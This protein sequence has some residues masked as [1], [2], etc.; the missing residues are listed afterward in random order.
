MCRRDAPGTGRQYEGPLT[1]WKGTAPGKAC[2]GRLPALRKHQQAAVQAQHPVCR[3]APEIPQ[4][5]SVCEG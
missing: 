4:R 2:L 1:Y 5:P 3:P